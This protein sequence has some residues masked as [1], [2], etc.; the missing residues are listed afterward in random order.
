MEALDDIFRYNAVGMLLW[1][2]VLMYRDFCDRLSCWLGTLSA[3]CA[4]AYLLA[5]K[6]GLTVFG[7][8][9]DLFL[10]PFAVFTPAAAWLFCLSQF[11]DHFRVRPWHLVVC[12]AK[13]ITGSIAYYQW[14][15]AGHVHP[16][17]TPAGVA[18]GVV[19]VGILSHLTYVAWRGRH[20][21]LVEARRRF[22]T[23]FVSSVI[24][25]SVGVLLAETF[26]VGYGYE[27]YL[28]LLQAS[29][30]LIIALYLNWRLT[31]SDGGD[32]F[33]SSEN[34]AQA[35]ASKNENREEPDQHDLV[36]IKKLEAEGF[37]LEQGLTIARM[38]EA[39]AMP[40]HRLRRLINQHL[41]YRNF[42][43][44][45]NHHRIETARTRLACVEDRNLPVLTIAMD[46]GYGSLGPFNRAF[47]ARTGLTPTEFRKQ[48][49]STGA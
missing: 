24:V 9:I 30:F 18:A 27:P 34:R 25:I 11:D 7:L 40:E 1:L 20:D 21:D 17:V 45:L 6:P 33:F 10:F 35:V 15:A 29:V 48:A 19:I 28:L 42:A 32:L 36:V 31:Q 39:A 4:A 47:K 23:I 26:L 5:S 41:G 38:A 13:L 22:R 49:L 44:Y 14:G 12:A 37:V 46:L 3:V 8:D 2:S 16:G 43:D